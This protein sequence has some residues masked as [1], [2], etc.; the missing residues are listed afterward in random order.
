MNIRTVKRI[1]KGYATKDGAGVKLIRVLGHDDVKDIDPFLML[2]AFGS[3]DYRDFIKGFPMHPH[4][5]IETITYLLDG[6]IDHKDSI[7]NSGTLAGG[8]LQWMTSGSGILHEEMP[9]KTEKLKGLQFWLNLPKDKKMA[10]P[11][12]FPISA[13]ML[14]EIVID[15][16]KIK[17]IAGEYNGI[18]AI[19]SAYVKVT[20]M[21]V[22]LSPNSEH[23]FQIPESQNCFVYVFDGSG[24][25]DDQDFLVEEHN[26]AIFN[27]GDSIFVKALDKGVHFI[28]LAAVPLNEPIAWAGPIVMNTEEEIR[29]AFKELESGNFIK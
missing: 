20:M 5:G 17:L 24:F 1:V 23:S 7:G 25:F 27:G 9:Q 12:Y 28:L 3:D 26:V 21:D 4:R 18:K 22:T 2:D 8:E 6:R 29:E 16:G 13:D 11:N 19:E 14:H 10:K 15:G